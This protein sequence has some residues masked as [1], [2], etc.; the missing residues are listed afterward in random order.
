[1]LLYIMS[2]EFTFNGGIQPVERG[3]VSFLLFFVVNGEEVPLHT[4]V[5]EGMVLPP[6]AS[7]FGPSLVTSKSMYHTSCSLLKLF[8]METGFGVQKRY[9]SFYMQ[10]QNAVVPNVTVH[11]FGEAYTVERF[12]FEGKVRF[13]KKGEAMENLAE[14]SSSRLFLKKQQPVP[15]RL[16]QRMIHVDRSEIRKGIRQIRIGQRKKSS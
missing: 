11:P 2:Y 8:I 5:R 3:K 10:L 4:M 7:P 9:H 14:G 15:I 16:L 12:F 1:M 13:L 6:I